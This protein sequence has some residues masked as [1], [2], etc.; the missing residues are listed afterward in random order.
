MSKNE[1]R[2]VTVK[3][4]EKMLDHD[5]PT[6]EAFLARILAQA[7]P[8]NAKSSLSDDMTALAVRRVA[9]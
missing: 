9:P 4:L 3:Q 5:A 7:V 1:Q 8:N 2:R 6:A